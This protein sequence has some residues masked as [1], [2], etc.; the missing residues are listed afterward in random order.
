MDSYCGPY[1]SDGK[2]QSSVE[3]GA[4]TPEDEVAGQCRLHDSA[5]KHF[6]TRQHHKAAD[7]LFYDNI[8]NLKDLS[9]F[10]QTKGWVAKNLVK[11][12][13]GALR[14]DYSYPDDKTI[15][16][17][18]EYY[19]HDPMFRGSLDNR[20]VGDQEVYSP[21]GPS[22]GDLLD[23]NDI[24]ISVDLRATGQGQ[25]QEVYDPYRPRGFASMF[26]NGFPDYAVPSR[27][28]LKRIIGRPS[29]ASTSN[30]K[31]QPKNIKNKKSK[32]KKNKI[33]INN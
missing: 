19:N 30:H 28:V 10:N 27:H 18:K 2:F 1:W 9:L 21:E 6:K 25:N 12:V 33:H 26:T 29:M 11:Y 7:L 3:F 15:Q 23:P 17:V 8:T 20:N 22:M 16:E 31:T 14:F 5:Y 4:T 13:N 32:K 24:G